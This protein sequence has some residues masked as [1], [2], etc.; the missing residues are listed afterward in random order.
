MYYVFNQHK[1]LNVY[2]DF[3]LNFRAKHGQILTS[4][5]ETI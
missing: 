5:K 2:C 4:E 3:P 1:N